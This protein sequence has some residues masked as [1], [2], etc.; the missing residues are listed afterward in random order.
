[1]LFVTPEYN[2]SFPGV[3][4]NAIDHASRP[5]GRVHLPASR[6]A[7]S[8]YRSARSARRS[9]SSISATRSPI[10]TSRPLASP[11]HLSRPKKA[12]SNPMAAL[13]PQADNFC[14]AGSTDT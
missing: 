10:S 6:P 4:K 7:S 2:R 9:R 12:C 3:L 8:G 1:L 13:A 14:K 5:T 11:R